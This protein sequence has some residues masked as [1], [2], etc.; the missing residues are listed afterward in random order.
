[1]AAALKPSGEVRPSE[2]STTRGALYLS[3]DRLKVWQ[4]ILAIAN[5]GHNEAEAR[6]LIAHGA[7]MALEQH[8]ANNGGQTAAPAG[9]VTA[10]QH[11]PLEELLRVFPGVIV[12]PTAERGTCSHPELHAAH[13]WPHPES[14]RVVCQ[15]C[16]PPPAQPR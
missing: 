13:H 5:E 12:E 8:R 4:Q 9:A 16:Y 11:S 2:R 1:M 7:R 6:D 10:R 14:G 3:R 15:C